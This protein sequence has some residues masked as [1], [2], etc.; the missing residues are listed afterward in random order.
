MLCLYFPGALG[1]WNQEKNWIILIL[2]TARILLQY[3]ITILRFI[4]NTN[5]VK[6]YSPTTSIFIAESFWNFAK[7]TAVIPPCPV[8]NFKMIQFLWN[9]LWENKLLW[10]FQSR[11]IIFYCNCPQMLPMNQ[12]DTDFCW[13]WNEYSIIQIIQLLLYNTLQEIHKPGFCRP[14]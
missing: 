1:G 8:H 12:S 14:I 11:L 10:D 3:M 5:V 4:F 2:V 9:T 7:S 13:I 6:S